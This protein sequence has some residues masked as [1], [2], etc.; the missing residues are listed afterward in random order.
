MR[1]K[2]REATL[3]L[4]K[5]NPL[6]VHFREAH[7]KKD[8]EMHTHDLHTPTTILLRAR[9]AQ[10]SFI[11]E[12]HVQLSRWLTC[13]EKN[14]SAKKLHQQLHAWLREENGGGEL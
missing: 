3:P 2:L 11:S 6:A 13:F 10:L 1:N 12:L 8:H 5:K 4:L 7:L 9:L 14:C